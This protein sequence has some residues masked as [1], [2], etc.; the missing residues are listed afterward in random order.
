LGLR[1]APLIESLTHDFCSEVSHLSRVRASAFA[2]ARNQRAGEQAFHRLSPSCPIA[3]VR[4]YL[5]STPVLFQ[6][7]NTARHA[8]ALPS[9]QPIKKIQLALHRLSEETII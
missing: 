9:R 4:L 2:N 7:D 3:L 8:A 5:L 1:T 6:Q